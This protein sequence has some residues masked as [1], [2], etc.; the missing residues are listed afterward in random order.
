MA[1]Y[2]REFLVPYV[3]DIFSLHMAHRKIENKIRELKDLYE[4]YECGYEAVRPDCV[5]E[6]ESIGC[7][8]VLGLLVG[9]FLTIGGLITP[10]SPIVEEDIGVAMFVTIGGL[11]VGV[12]ILVKTIMWAVEVNKENNARYDEHNRQ[13]KEYRGLKKQLKIQNQENLEKLP[14]LQNEI[15]F[16]AKEE[17]R[18]E[19]L[20]KKLYNVNIIP[21]RYRDIYAATYLYD[22]FY[23]GSSDDL[24]MALNTYVLEQIKDR[25]DQ[26]IE[27]QRDQILM[28]RQQLALQRESL[29]AQKKHAA[30]MEKR[31]AQLAAN[32]ETQTQYLSMIEGNT[33]ATAYFALAQYLK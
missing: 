6:E 15:D 32:A 14:A 31:I 12:P 9:A 30:Y 24:D 28:Q 8:G 18:V 7:F 19:W 26:I 4:E 1:R 17:A 13:M 10:F 23:Y 16:Y 21:L 25:L 33:Q 11:L 22:Y 2:D 3:Q 27:N 29:E 5:V 20:L